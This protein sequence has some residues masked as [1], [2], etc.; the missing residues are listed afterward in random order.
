MFQQVKGVRVERSSAP[1]KNKQTAPVPVEYQ[2]P[3]VSVSYQANA[4]P[5]QP[6][7]YV[8]L[9]DAGASQF[10]PR[11][12]QAT[13]KFALTGPGTVTQKAMAVTGPTSPVFL[14]AFNIQRQKLLVQGMAGVPAQYPVMQP[15][16]D[17]PRSGP[18]T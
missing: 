2:R 11:R 17:M 15:L 16:Y 8:P 18:A 9:P 6:Y 5:K 3:G 4:R 12:W 14:G 13:P 1:I 10:V 7:K